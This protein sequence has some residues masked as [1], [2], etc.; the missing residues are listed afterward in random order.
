MAKEYTFTAR[1]EE[2]RLKVGLR[3]LN[4]LR[5]AVK[6]WR[7]CPVTVTVERQHATRS[8]QANRYYWGVVIEHISEHTG[9][10][11]EE[12]H[13]ALKTLFLPKRLAM[14]GE[15]GE[16]HS[17]LV[18]GGST[19]ALNKVEFYEYCERIREFALD[20]LGVRIPAPDPAWRE[21]A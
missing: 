8:D 14:L 16:L 5:E 15:N 10:T 20:K 12:T 17:D 21:A 18:I 13:D 2:G 1:I 11:P 19:T 3:A 6:G 7:S 4:L 9:Y